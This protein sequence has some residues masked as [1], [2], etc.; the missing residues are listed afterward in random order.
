MSS[1]KLDSSARLFT[2]YHTEQYIFQLT[3]VSEKIL[4]NLGAEKPTE[5]KEGRKDD[6]GHYVPHKSVTCVG[7][8]KV[9]TL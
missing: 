9:V 2:L 5:R 1:P 6:L 8:I 7:I 4:Y 3:G